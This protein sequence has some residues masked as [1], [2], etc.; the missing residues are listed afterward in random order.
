MVLRDRT[1]CLL[2]ASEE[3]VPQIICGVPLLL[4]QR[5]KS[6]MVQDVD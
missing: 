6:S 3:R 4:Y 5:T 2:L 1:D